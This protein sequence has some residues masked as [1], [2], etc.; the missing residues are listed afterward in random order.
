MTSSA[1]ASSNL[2][3]VLVVANLVIASAALCRLGDGRATIVY[4]P[5]LS[6]FAAVVYPRLRT[7]L[8]IALVSYGFIVVVAVAR[9]WPAFGLAVFT[10]FAAGSP[11]LQLGQAIWLFV[12]VYLPLTAL[13]VAL[14]HFDL[15]SDLARTRMWRLALVRKGLTALLMVLILRQT[16][17]E[18]YALTI[19]MLEA[20]GVR[21]PRFA[22]GLRLARYWLPP[23][24]SAAITDALER[25]ALLAHLQIARVV[26]R[27]RERDVVV[28]PY[29][30][31]L[32]VAAI[33][34]LALIA[35]TYRR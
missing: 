32:A 29:Q 3:V 20:R 25:Y 8:P 23:S 14:D 35:W 31:L 10:A 2:T 9:N 13:V 15:P 7:L 5:L 12:F 11:A 19:E 28:A 22:P 34:D 16:I 18:R 4:A 27:P 17:V 21:V 1:R 33:L 26:V 24:V 6:C 30:W